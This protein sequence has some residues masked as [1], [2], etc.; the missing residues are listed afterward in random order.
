MYMYIGTVNI[1][2]LNEI[3][4]LSINIIIIITFCEITCWYNSILG[5]ARRSECW[6]KRISRDV[7]DS[8]R[9]LLCSAQFKQVLGKVLLIG[10]IFSDLSV[11]LKCE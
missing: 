4:F 6:L 7:K 3:L 10:Y 2:S 11:N 9:N 1:F 8:P 5:Y